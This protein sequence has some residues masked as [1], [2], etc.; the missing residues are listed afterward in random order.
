MVFILFEDE[1]DM[2]IVKMM[3]GSMIRRDFT[4]NLKETLKCAKIGTRNM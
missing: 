1:T 3:V 2:N 4:E